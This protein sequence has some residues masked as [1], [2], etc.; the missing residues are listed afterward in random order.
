MSMLAIFSMLLAC[1]SSREGRTIAALSLGSVV[2]GPKSSW[3][4]SRSSWTISRLSTGTP[5]TGSSGHPDED[6]EV[7]LEKSCPQRTPKAPDASLEKSCPQEL[8]LEKSSGHPPEAP[9]VDLD[10]IVAPRTW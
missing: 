10:Q 5:R 1:C 8:A 9:E 2:P 4:A 6:Q 3:A 7:A